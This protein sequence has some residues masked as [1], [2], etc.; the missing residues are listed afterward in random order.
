VEKRQGVDLIEEAK[1]FELNNNY[2]S[3]QI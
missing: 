2:V 1:I 3:T